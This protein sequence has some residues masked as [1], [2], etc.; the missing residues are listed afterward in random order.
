MRCGEILTP[1]KI[2]STG[3]GRISVRQIRLTMPTKREIFSTTT[4]DL[5]RQKSTKLMELFEYMIRPQTL[6][7]PT[8]RMGPREHSSSQHLRLTLT[9]SRAIR[10]NIVEETYV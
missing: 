6:L 4:P 2:T 10:H 7:V 1:Y 3:T 8:M 9:G 5:L